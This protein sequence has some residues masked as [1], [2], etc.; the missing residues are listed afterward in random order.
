MRLI[1]RHLSDR[2]EGNT[3]SSNLLKQQLIDPGVCMRYN[4]CEAMYSEF[5]PEFVK[6]HRG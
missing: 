1:V 4:S 5:V 2:G 3:T 6:V